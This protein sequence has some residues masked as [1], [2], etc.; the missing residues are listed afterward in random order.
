MKNCMR[1]LLVTALA[2]GILSLIG[3]SG[4]K[5]AQVNVNAMIE[6][7]KKEDKDARVNACVELAKAGPKAAPAVSALIPV[8][9]DKDA[10]VRRLAAYTLYEIGIEA[11]AAVPAVKE[12]MS[13]PDRSVVM[14]AVN[15][16]R[17]ID[18]AVAGMKSPPNVS[19][20]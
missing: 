2:F 3:C 13:D 4:E 5:P 9:K 11:K 18:P 12:M 1:V 6:E 15:T 8:L 14:Q 17:A 19:Q 7:L 10:E 16:L 20:P